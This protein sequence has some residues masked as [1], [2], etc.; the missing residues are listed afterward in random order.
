MVVDIL[1]E[2]VAESHLKTTVDECAERHDALARYFNNALNGWET[3]SRAGGAFSEKMKELDTPNQAGFLKPDG[4]MDKDKKGWHS[5]PSSC[6]TFWLGLEEDV[7]LY[8]FTPR[9][10]ECVDELETI[11]VPE[12][13]DPQK[14]AGGFDDYVDAC[15]RVMY[16]KNHF[17]VVG[18]VKAFN[19]KY[20]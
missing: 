5:G 11:F 2:E 20:R 12:G 13:E 9:S 18:E 4:T 7:R 17:G 3:N 15:S 1:G 10:K 6:R 8:Q 16:L 14:V 19:F